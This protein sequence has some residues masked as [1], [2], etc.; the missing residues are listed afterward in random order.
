MIDSCKRFVLETK[1]LILDI[2]YLISNLILKY[3]YI[4]TT[5]PPKVYLSY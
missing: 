2:K 3:L 4:S 5:P 1:Y